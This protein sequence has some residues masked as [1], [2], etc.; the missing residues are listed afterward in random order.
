M[1]PAHQFWRFEIS[2]YGLM[3]IF[4]WCRFSFFVNFLCSFFGSKRVTSH[5]PRSSI[6]SFQSRR[7]V[8]I[9]SRKNIER[10]W[11]KRNA[12][13]IILLLYYITLLFQ[14]SNWLFTYCIDRQ[15]TPNVIEFCKQKTSWRR[16]LQSA[17]PAVTLPF[18]ACVQRSVCRQ[19]HREVLSMILL[20]LPKKQLDILLERV[21]ERPPILHL[22]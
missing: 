11:R 21:L 22:S 17:L 4:H 12:P 1:L 2:G 14:F 13:S 10:C 16:C 15:M 20:P 3:F 8:D 9:F 7:F 19:S 5:Q 6:D 18:A